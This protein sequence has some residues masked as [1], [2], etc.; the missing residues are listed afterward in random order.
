MFSYSRHVILKSLK[1]FESNNQIY[2]KVQSCNASRK[3]D[4]KVKKPESVKENEDVTAKKRAPSCRSSTSCVKPKFS[5]W[6][7]I[8][9]CGIPYKAIYSFRRLLGRV[10]YPWVVYSM[11]VGKIVFEIV[12]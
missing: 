3:S 5:I 1:F 6:R 10:S 9:R 4:V 8:N 2:I 12:F 11:P 7:L